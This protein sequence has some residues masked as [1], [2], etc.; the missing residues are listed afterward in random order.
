MPR[1]EQVG[2]RGR[3]GG[4]VGGRMWEGRGEEGDG[5][6]REKYMH[7]LKHELY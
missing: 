1:E 7:H 3:K 2:E 5:H 4:K 6:G